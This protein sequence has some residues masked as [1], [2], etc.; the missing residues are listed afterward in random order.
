MDPMPSSEKNFL[1]TTQQLAGLENIGTTRLINLRSWQADISN[2]PI[3]KIWVIPKA[4]KRSYLQQKI[5]VQIL[6]LWHTFKSVPQDVNLILA[7][8]TNVQIF[9]GNWTEDTLAN[10]LTSKL[11]TQGITVEYDPYQ[12]QFRFCPGISIRSDSTANKY[13]GFPSGVDITNVQSSSFPPVALRGPQCIN[14]W[15]NFTMN[16]IPVSQFLSCI[17]INT[18]YG[19][20][21]FHTNY[22]NSEST[23]CLESDITNIRVILRDDRGNDLEYP[24]DLDWEITLAMIPTIPEG[25]APL[26]M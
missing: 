7:D 5:G 11:T 6:K 26:E 16:N 13:L 12:F 18:T 22:D 23:L 14:V 9:K 8:S 3:D 1:Q 4:N 10:Y 2:S 24:E 25:F 20:Y 19:G 21:I 17:P 15:T